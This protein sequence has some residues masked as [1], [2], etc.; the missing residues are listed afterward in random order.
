MKNR[1]YNKQLF[2]TGIQLGTDYDYTGLLIY[3]VQ[4][5]R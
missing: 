4:V 1:G 3:G 2:P 5:F